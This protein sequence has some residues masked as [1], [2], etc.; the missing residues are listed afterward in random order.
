MHKVTFNIHFFVNHHVRDAV[1]RPLLNARF[2]SLVA[3][4]VEK[5]KVSVTMSSKTCVPHRPRWSECA[6]RCKSDQRGSG[7]GSC[8]S[9]KAVS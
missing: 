6:K 9:L 1:Q 2:R 5:R 3:E 8:V 4:T 7:A